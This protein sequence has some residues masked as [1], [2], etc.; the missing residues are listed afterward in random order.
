MNFRTWITAAGLSMLAATSFAQDA[1]ASAPGTHKPR[2]DARQARQEQRIDQGIAS[3]ELTQRETRRLEREQAVINRAEDK[4]R[5]D[6]T[7]TTAER[8][9]LHKMQ[10]HASRDIRRQKHDGQDRH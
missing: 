4:A 6:G 8:K 2:I 5:A 3:G 1:A 10:D 7:V 9:R